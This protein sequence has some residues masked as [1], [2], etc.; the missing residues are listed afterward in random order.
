MTK[1]CPKCNRSSDDVRF[2]GQFCEYCVIDRIGSDL[3]KEIK[4]PLCRSCGRIKTHIGFVASSP[5]SLDDAVRFSIH[6]PDFEVS[7]V[8]YDKAT[9]IAVVQFEKEVEGEPVQFTKDIEIKFTNILCPLCNRERSGY[10]EAEIQLRGIYSKLS[11]ME[12]RILD[13]VNKNG[14]FVSQIKEDKNGVNIYIG[15]RDVANAFFQSNKKLKP[16]KSYEL[17][18]LKAG[19]RVYRNIYSLRFE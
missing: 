1:Y 19:K 3:P 14:S 7:L 11:V 13:F 6:R 16:I 4:I 17:Y 15:S 8:S 10:Y 9:S 18:G 5:D 12:K 2:I